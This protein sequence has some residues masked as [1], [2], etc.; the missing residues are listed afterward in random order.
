MSDAPPGEPEPRQLLVAGCATYAVM[1]IGALAWLGWRGRLDQLAEQSFGR[2]GPWSA[3]AAGLAAGLLMAF[4]IAWL[5]PRWGVLRDLD[6][7]VG[8]TFAGIGEAATLALVLWGALA[9][10][11]LFRL[12]A[13]DALGLYG[14]VALHTFLY[15]SAAGWRLLFAVLPHA[16]LLGVL[17]DSGFGL[18]ASTA[19][20]AIMNHLNL[21]R[22]RC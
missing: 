17:V 21:R 13:Q 15:S 12:A 7:M 20:N 3:A 8:R 19:A 14:A 22:L 10:E 5:S 2:H 11:L 18:L 1:A 4:G 6:A 9:E 16:L